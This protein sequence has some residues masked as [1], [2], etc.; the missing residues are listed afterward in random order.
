MHTHTHFLYIYTYIYIL[1]THIIH[2]VRMCVCIYVC[3]YVHIYVC[4]CVYI[5][6]LKNTPVSFSFTWLCCDSTWVWSQSDRYTLWCYWPHASPTGFHWCPLQEWRRWPVMS[7]IHSESRLG[8]YR[9]W[10]GRHPSSHH[11]PRHVAT[12]SYQGN[13]QAVLQRANMG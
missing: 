13:P 1:H 3:I 10:P 8:P 5:Y 2:N 4:V 11:V 9:E 6:S 7:V 12:T